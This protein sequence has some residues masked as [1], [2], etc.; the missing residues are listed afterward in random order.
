MERYPQSSECCSQETFG[1][2]TRQHVPSNIRH[3]RCLDCTST[4]ALSPRAAEEWER[5]IC[6]KPSLFH[7]A[8]SPRRPTRAYQKEMLV[9]IVLERPLDEAKATLVYLAPGEALR[10]QKCH[11]LL[12]EIYT[13]VHIG[14]MCY[15]SGCNLHGG[16]NR[17][18]SMV[19]LGRTLKL[20]QNG[21][22]TTGI[23][24]NTVKMR[25]M[26]M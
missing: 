25:F 23:G 3:G 14:C 2:S 17:M 8:S 6:E 15:V 18:L 5:C 26:C 13:S 20:M 22:R 12:M 10:K 7:P 1:P 19:Y 16:H 24:Y 9:S 21:L 4:D 11:K